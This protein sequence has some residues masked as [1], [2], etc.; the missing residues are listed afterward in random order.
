MATDLMQLV[1]IGLVY[2]SRRHTSVNQLLILGAY[3]MPS[4][5]LKSLTC[6]RF[7]DDTT[8]ELSELIF[9]WQEGL[10]S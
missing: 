5:Q 9:L 4:R 6:S 8:E 7:I 3:L 1:Q 10:R 2:L